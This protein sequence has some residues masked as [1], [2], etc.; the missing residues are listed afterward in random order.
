M[1]HGLKVM[2]LLPHLDTGSGS[3]LLLL[4]DFGLEARLWETQVRAL[5]RRYRVLVSDLPGLDP[6]AV[7][8]GQ[9]SPS[10]ELFRLL[11][12]KGVGPVHLVGLSLGG[13]VAVDLLLSHPEAVRTLV[14]IDALWWR[15][16]TPRPLL[17]SLRCPAL[18]LLSER[19]LPSSAMAMTYAATLPGAR[20][21][22]LER[23]DPLSP[24]EAPE[25]ISRR[26]LDFLR[27]QG[28]CGTPLPSSPRLTFRTWTPK[29]G[30]LAMKVWGDPRVTSFVL[31]QPFNQGQV[32]ERLR[33]EIERQTRHGMQY[34]PLFLRATGDLV[35]C[36]GL[37]P[38]ASDA[39]VLELG[40]LL[41]PEYWGL[42]LATEAALATVAHAFDVLGAAALF[43]G[44][45]PANAGSRHVLL[46]LG[47]QQTHVERYP[48]TGLEHPSYLLRKN[49]F[50]RPAPSP[51]ASSFGSPRSAAT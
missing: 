18:V 19:D 21:E 41:R 33:Q 44:H 15:R 40:F 39:D 22:V 45:H 47:F 16:A 12:A 49:D 14:L 2:E 36:C 48:P 8:V 17:G 31:A 26:L 24:A 34:S 9:V 32:Q 51:G 1:L 11:Q 29:D 7:E 28:A 5:E 27:G 42:G 37:R 13:A 38:R 6:K 35:G 50:R 25:R 4:H 30:S 43:A 23:L 3:P 20:L 10:E 46:K